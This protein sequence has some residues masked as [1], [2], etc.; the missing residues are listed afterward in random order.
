MTVDSCQG[1]NRLK[2]DRTVEEFRTALAERLGIASEALVFAGEATNGRQATDT[3]SV[4][5]LADDRDSVRL[6]PEAG[7]ALRRALRMLR[8]RGDA[9]CSLTE[10]ASRYITDGAL[11]DLEAAR[12]EQLFDLGEAEIS[13]PE[14]PV[15]LSPP[16]VRVRRRV[17]RIDAE[18]YEQLVAA[19]LFARTR[20]RPHMLVVDAM[21]E[22]AAAFVA[23]TECELNDGKPLPPVSSYD[24]ADVPALR[25]ESGRSPTRRARP[26]KHTLRDATGDSGHEG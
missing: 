8:A 13:E 22:A 17:I 10:L 12:R 3:S 15:V 25:E 1:C 9:R 23:H 6:W 18:I 11:G 20:E 14:A 16:K 5:S 21:D 2:G 7:E 19:V 24:D 26:T 4:S